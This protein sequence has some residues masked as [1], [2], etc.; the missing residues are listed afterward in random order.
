MAKLILTA[1]AVSLF[2]N[3]SFGQKKGDNKVIVNG[4]VSYNQIKTALFNEGFVTTN[5]DTVLIITTIKYL[6]W[7]SVTC[8]M[9]Q[10]TDSSVI[11]KGNCKPFSL[12]KLIAMGEFARTFNLPITFL[13]D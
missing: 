2:F 7:G 8:Y 12:K 1:I 10:K 5:S 6:D 11:F 4:Y 9:I 3:L 13:K